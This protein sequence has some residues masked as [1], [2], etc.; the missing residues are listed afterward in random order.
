MKHFYNT[1]VFCA[2]VVLN[3]LQAEITIQTSASC[4]NPCSGSIEINISS[5]FILEN[6]F[7][8]PLELTIINLTEETSMD[9]EIFSNNFMVPDLCVG[10]YKVFI[11]FDDACYYEDV[12][13][14]HSFPPMTITGEASPNCD[15]KS[16]IGSIQIAVEGGEGPFNVLWV[17]SIPGLYPIFNSVKYIEGLEDFSSGEQNLSGMPAGSYFVFI[18][19]NNGCN[20]IKHFTISFVPLLIDFPDADPIC[21]SGLGGPLLPT[22][23][24]AE[25]PLDAVW[26]RNLVFGFLPVHTQN[27]VTAS[28]LMLNTYN[29]WPIR[30]TVTDDRG[31]RASKEFYAEFKDFP[32]ENSHIHISASASA[33]CDPNRRSLQLRC[34]VSS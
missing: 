28:E 22:V 34:H 20:T 9:Y 27:G 31:C 29:I 21:L 18:S 25:E 19:D 32:I 14:I 8:F 24:N 1:I 6:E 3:T 7:E 16:P 12:V 13:H 17:K 15:M 26:E 33:I 23:Q 5:N 4:S 2:I 10:D 11:Y 30:L